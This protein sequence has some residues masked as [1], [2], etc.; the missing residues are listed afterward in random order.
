MKSLLK[1]ILLFILPALF[2]VVAPSVEAKST[3]AERNLIKDGNKAFADS[4]YVEAFA[5]Y[6]KALA[7]NPSRKAILPML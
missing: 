2:L 3:K 4:N 1:Y 6:E 5:Y 7:E